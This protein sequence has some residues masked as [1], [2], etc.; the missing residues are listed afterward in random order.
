MA[1][2]Y[3]RRGCRCTTAERSKAGRVCRWRAG[4][5]RRWMAV[6]FLET[7]NRL[8]RITDCRHMSGVEDI[9]DESKPATRRAVAK[10]DVNRRHGVLTT[11]GA[12]RKC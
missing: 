11:A 8:R 6:A 12:P 2:W 10:T 1:R 7:E 3:N 5:A 9:P 4:M